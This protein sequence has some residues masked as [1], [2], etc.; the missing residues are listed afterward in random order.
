MTKKDY[1]KVKISSNRSSRSSSYGPGSTVTQLVP[2]SVDIFQKLLDIKEL[3]GCAVSV[4]GG[5]NMTKDKPVES[6]QEPEVVLLEPENTYP[7][8]DTLVV[9]T[10]DEVVISEESGEE[11]ENDG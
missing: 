4:A 9:P 11:S 1:S 2:A 7:P 6:D 5:G 8:M 3:N 10:I